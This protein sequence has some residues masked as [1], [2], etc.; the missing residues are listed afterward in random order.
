MLAFIGDRTIEPFKFDDEID[1]YPDIENSSS[2][3]MLESISETLAVE[4]MTLSE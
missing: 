4:S 2:V 3:D 1:H